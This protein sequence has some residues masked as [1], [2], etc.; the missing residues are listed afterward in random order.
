MSISGMGEFDDVEHPVYM[1]FDWIID[2]DPLHL[3][4]DDANLAQRYVLSL[5]YFSTGGD[6][7]M[8]CRRDGL[9]PCIEEN[10]LSGSHECEWGG[11]TCDSLKRVK[12]LNIGKWQTTISYPT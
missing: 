5:L 9:A 4:P 8:K 12:N 6:N 3:C 7:W 10:F 2:G 1:A 11:I